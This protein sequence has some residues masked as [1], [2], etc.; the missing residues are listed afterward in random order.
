MR[1][2]VGVEGTCLHFITL[3]FEIVGVEAIVYCRLRHGSGTWLG[4][5][6]HGGNKSLFNSPCPIIGDELV[7]KGSSG[8]GWV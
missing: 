3:R 1:F 7:F 8:G 2:Q 5:I 6:I 4:F